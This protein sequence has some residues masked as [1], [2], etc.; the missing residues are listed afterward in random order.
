M[1]LMKV[2]Y[3]SAGNNNSGDRFRDTCE[4]KKLTG[5]DRTDRLLAKENNGVMR[6][7]LHVS[8]IA[9]QWAT[10]AYARPSCVVKIKGL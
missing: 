4:R 3:D 10:D 5:S 8:S 9:A 2:C 6:Y 7:I 1:P